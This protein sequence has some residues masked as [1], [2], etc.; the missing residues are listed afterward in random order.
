MSSCDCCMPCVVCGGWTDG[1]GDKHPECR[2]TNS[3]LIGQTADQ[4]GWE[5]LGQIT[6]IENERNRI[7]RIIAT[8]DWSGE[9]LA[10]D[11]AN[12][13]Q[14]ILGFPLVSHE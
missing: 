2:T 3:E 12:L 6:G 1:T 11:R 10:Q 4:K 5:A 8:A 7:L 13:C 9:D 14:L